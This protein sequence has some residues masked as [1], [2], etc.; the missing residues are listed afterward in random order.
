MLRRK[1]TAKNM[2]SWFSNN[3]KTHQGKRIKNSNKKSNNL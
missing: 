3:I 1:A 2:K